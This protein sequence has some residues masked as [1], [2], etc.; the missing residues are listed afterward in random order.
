MKG[1]FIFDMVNAKLA[2]H[3]PPAV[4]ARCTVARYQA[5]TTEINKICCVGT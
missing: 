2:G 1:P 3:L 4:E 5:D